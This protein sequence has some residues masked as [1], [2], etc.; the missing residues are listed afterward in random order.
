[1]KCRAGART[2]NHPGLPPYCSPRCAC[3][4]PVYC[5]EVGSRNL[6]SKSSGVP[7]IVDPNPFAKDLSMLS[8]TTLQRTSHAS[9]CGSGPS[10]MALL[11]HSL[12][13]TVDWR[14]QQMRVHKL[15]AKRIKNWELGVQMM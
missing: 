5:F 10:V 4:C 7:H 3:K 9:I 6:P 8:P 14:I 1:M 13:R 11:L 15:K 12:V 2:R